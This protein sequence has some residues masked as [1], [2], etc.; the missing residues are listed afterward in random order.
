MKIKRSKLIIFKLPLS[1]NGHKKR[2]TTVVVSFG[3]A[4]HK[5]HKRNEKKGKAVKL[6]PLLVLSI[7]Q[8]S[9]LNYNVHI[10]TEPCI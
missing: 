4:S 5:F 1:A 8:M 2:P 3:E 9:S 6:Y 7:H 10:E